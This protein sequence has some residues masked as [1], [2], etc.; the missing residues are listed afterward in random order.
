MDTDE[1]TDDLL[2]L[3]LAIC[4]DFF[5]SADP[6]VHHEADALLRVRSSTGG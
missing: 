2:P 3:L 5:A 6:A 4:E 1:P